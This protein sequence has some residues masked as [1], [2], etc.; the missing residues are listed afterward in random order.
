MQAI[1]QDAARVLLRDDIDDAHVG[2]QVVHAAFHPEVGDEGDGQH[3][4]QQEI[5]GME[6][7]IAALQH[8]QQ[9]RGDEENKAADDS[10][11]M[12][13]GERTAYDHSG[14]GSRR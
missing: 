4:N 1:E 2:F 8:G 9:Y 11:P 6:D 10:D 13:A 5:A 7:G 3:G 12:Q 14:K